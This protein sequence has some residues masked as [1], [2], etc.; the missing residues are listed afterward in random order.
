MPLDL[1]P[2]IQKLI[3]DRLAQI[4]DEIVINDPEYKELSQKVSE[5]T[6]KITV[7]LTPED[8]KLMDEQEG[9]W[10]ANYAAMKRS[11]MWK[12]RWTGCSG[13]IGRL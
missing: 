5:W 1:S 2:G 7:K 6:K 13:G 12:D 9:S 11:F 3:L 10:L 8:R 4:N